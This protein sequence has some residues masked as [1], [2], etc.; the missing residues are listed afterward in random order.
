MI[1]APDWR[2]TCGWSLLSAAVAAWF[3]WTDDIYPSAIGSSQI[4]A[5]LLVCTLSR[6]WVLNST[7][8]LRL[9]HHE[10]YC[11]NFLLHLP[12]RC[13]TPS[14]QFIVK[15]EP[16]ILGSGLLYPSEDRCPIPSS[17]VNFP[18]PEHDV[19]NYITGSGCEVNIGWVEGLQLFVLIIRT[20]NTSKGA[21]MLNS[22]HPWTA[23]FFTRF[24]FTL[25]YSP[26]SHNVKLD[27][28]S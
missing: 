6:P 26:G 11:L 23:L 12:C 1:Y 10:L 14:S 2:G 19:R 22:R 16:R 24:N 4:S 15:K 17:S 7:G 18:L 27:A 20:W 8:P 9:H 5:T 3:R 28:L 25:S 21:K 13:L